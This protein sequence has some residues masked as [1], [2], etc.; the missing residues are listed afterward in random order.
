[1]PCCSN[2]A[3][4]T[5]PLAGVDSSTVDEVARRACCQREVESRV[6]TRAELFDSP[7]SV[8]ATDGSSWSRD[9]RCAGRSRIT[10]SHFGKS[11]VTGVGNNDLVVSILSNLHC[12]RT[13]FAALNAA[14][15]NEGAPFA[16]GG[17]GVASSHI[18]YVADFSTFASGEADVDFF[19]LA[20][21]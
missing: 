19:R 9:D 21:F 12:L 17:V 8:V 18:G 10:N 15:G 2:F 14:L 4:A 5:A 16:R 3:A 6:L 20:R 1:M 11:F 7:H 13:H